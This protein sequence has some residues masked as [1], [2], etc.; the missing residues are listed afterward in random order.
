MSNLLST[1]RLLVLTAARSVVSHRM[2]S[3]IVGF[4]LMFGTALL[5]VGTSLLDSVEESMQ[6][7]VTQSLAGHLQV[8][9]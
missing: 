4:I 7:T 9:S 5:V 1:F 6:R 2:K 8:Y 3:L